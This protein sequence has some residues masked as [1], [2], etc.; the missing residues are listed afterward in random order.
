MNA[1]ITSIVFFYTNWSRIFI[2]TYWHLSK[3]RLFEC[4]NS[5]ILEKRWPSIGEWSDGA[6]LPYFT[7]NFG[8]TNSCV[9][10]KIDP[11][12]L[13]Y[14]R[15]QFLFDLVPLEI[16]RLLFSFR[17]MLNRSFK[18]PLRA[19]SIGAFWDCVRLWGIYREQSFFMTKLWLNILYMSVELTPKVASLSENVI[20]WPC[21]ITFCTSPI[22]SHTTDFELP[23]QLSF[24]SEWR[25]QLNS[26]YQHFTVAKDSSSS[27][28]VEVNLSMHS[29]VINHVENH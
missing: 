2:Y 25:P 18:A 24:V 19:K 20:W 16:P 21:I 15:E 9:P 13:F 14:E 8:K 7:E 3:H 4:S 28:N 5:F 11:F 10:L 27:P 26:L 6:C 23:S 17:L 29:V 12:T 1:Y 22:S